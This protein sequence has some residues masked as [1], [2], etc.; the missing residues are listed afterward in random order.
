MFVCGECR[1]AAAVCRCL[2]SVNLCK[3]CESAHRG[4]CRAGSRYCVPLPASFDQTPEFQLDNTLH[5]AQLLASLRTLVSAFQLRSQRLVDSILQQQVDI[6]AAMQATIDHY[7]AESEYFPTTILNDLQNSVSQACQTYISTVASTLLDLKEAIDFTFGPIDFQLFY[8]K[9]KSLRRFDCELG[10]WVERSLSLFPASEAVVTMGAWDVV[11]LNERKILHTGGGGINVPIQN[12]A[13][14]IDV[15]SGEVERVQDMIVA[16]KDHTGLEVDGKVFI[17]GGKDAQGKIK[18]AEVFDLRER[19][20]AE[21]GKMKKG[22]FRLNPILHNSRI[23]LAG[24]CDYSIEYFD[25]NDLQFHLLPVSLKKESATLTLPQSTATDSQLLSLNQQGWQLWSED[26][27][28]VS[29]WTDKSLSLTFYMA[30][31]CFGSLFYVMDFDKVSEMS[32]DMKKSPREIPLTTK[33]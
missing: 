27:D 31:K 20:W 24:G 10:R 26:A 12:K 3:Q 29:Q 4:K 6:V 16:R 7:E 9:S 22:R 17:F 30:P 1:V 2:C 13:Q 28:S 32:L 14:L 8:I 21:L 33:L 11:L 5:G 15:A 18:R 25:L 23:L 19:Q